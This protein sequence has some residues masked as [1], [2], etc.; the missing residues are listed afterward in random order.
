M[1]LEHRK[2]E[3]HGKG[4]GFYSSFNWKLLETLQQRNNM[5]GATCFK[6]TLAAGPRWAWRAAP[7][8][9]GWPFRRPLWLLCERC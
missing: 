1:G 5:R 8:P 7:V 3:R 4:L 6:I 9:A 2:L